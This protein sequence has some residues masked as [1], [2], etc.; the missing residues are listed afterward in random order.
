MAAASN[1]KSTSATSIKNQLKQVQLRQS[2]RKYV[3]IILENDITF[4]YGPAG[5]SKTF[6]ACYI[7]LYTCWEIKK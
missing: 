7:Q 5:T 3:D 1:N 6:T 4:C 2:Q